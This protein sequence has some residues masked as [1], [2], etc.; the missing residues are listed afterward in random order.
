[1]SGTHGLGLLTI[2][3]GFLFILASVAALFLTIP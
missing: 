2:P 3:A 1:M